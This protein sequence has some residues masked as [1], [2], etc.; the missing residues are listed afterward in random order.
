MMLVRAEILR[1]TSRRAFRIVLAVVVAVTLF[2]GVIVFLSTRDASIRYT[3]V[4]PLSLRIAS[5]PLFSLAVVCGASFV[6]AE[7]ACG[8][9]TTLLTWEPRR[10][11]VLVAKLAAASA[12]SALTVFGVLVLV[13]LVLVPAAAAHGSISGVTGEWWGSTIGV[14]VRGTALGAL[15]AGLGVGLA[16]L[17]RNSGGPIAVWL[18]FDFVVSNLLVL[19]KP[20]LFRWMPGANAQ[21]FV[22]AEEIVGVSVNGRDLFDFSA[23][24]AGIVLAVYTGGL[25][26]ASYAWFRARDVA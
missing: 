7:W 25:L 4:A 26:A 24:R 8:G 12:L 19:W 21:Q 1:L 20:G 2:V 3:T 10:G 14:L 13:A 5:Q 17:V 9:M 18:I 22:S 15:G 11:R 23:L 6:G 16:G